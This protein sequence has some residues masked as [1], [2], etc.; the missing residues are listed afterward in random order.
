MLLLKRGEIK[1]NKL[2]DKIDT[3][4]EEKIISNIALRVVKGDEV[5]V[6]I[7][8]SDNGKIDENTI[9]DMA[10]VTKILSTSTLALIALDRGLISLDD[11]VSKFYN[12]DKNIT[13]LNLLTHTMGIGYK[14][15]YDMNVTSDNVADV[16]L[17]IPSD[18][19]VGSE[20]RYSCPGFI[21]LGKILEKVFGDTLD[22][23][24]F[25]FV[26]LP[27][28]MTSTSYLPEKKGKFVNANTDTE[29]G[30]VN[31]YNCRCL[32]GVAGNAGV[33]STMSDM[34]K[35]ARML[36]SLGSPIIKE[37]TFKKAIKNYTPLMSESR[38][39]GFL[40]VDERYMQTGSLFKEGSF[41]HCGHTGQSVFVNAQSRLSVIVLTDATK[42]VY[43]KF[44]SHE[45]YDVV[46]N[47][48]REL[49][50]AIRE[51]LN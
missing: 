19:E 43:E 45:H 17:S 34:T 51:Y 25:N 26:A 35:Y 3:F 29:V 48:R 30:I 38:G 8:K 42:K 5:L 14:P 2:I 16:I 10:S 21:L 18:F 36:T 50:E 47:M 46:M 6:D 9:F 37:E 32:G 41:G 4:F 22:K 23:L 39:L 33:F 12:T 24:F 20:V 15:L 1:M 44:S 49:H 27:L 28:G 7:Y 13:V 11:K 40:Y 31:D